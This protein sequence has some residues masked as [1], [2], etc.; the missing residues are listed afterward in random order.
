MG[1]IGRMYKIF[2]RLQR[3]GE[4]KNNKTIMLFTEEEFSDHLEKITHEQYE[5]SPDQI[6]KT[7]KKAEELTVEE[8]TSERNNKLII[9]GPSFEEIKNEIARTED[10]A[11]G[12]DEIRLRYFREA[13]DEINKGATAVGKPH[14]QME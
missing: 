6:L 11:S 7:I 13:G 14:T 2:Q 12:E 1:Q 4:H 9:Q 5:S 8:E 10:A 3:R